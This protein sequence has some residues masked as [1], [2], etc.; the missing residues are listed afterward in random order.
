MLPFRPLTLE[1]KAAVQAVVYPTD[2]RNCDLCF[3]NLMSWRFL[4]DTE[5][6]FVDGFLLLYF[7]ADGH[8]AYLFPVGMGDGVEMTRRLM[9]DAEERGHAF[10]MLGVCEDNMQR[11]KAAFPQ[12]F[13]ET[14]RNYADYVYERTALASLAGK[15]LQSKRNFVN[16]FVAAHPDYTYA[17]LTAAD[18][19]EC[20]ELEAQWCEQK[21]TNSARLSYADERRSMAYV[22]AHWDELGAT[23]G[24][25]RVDGRMVAFTLG[26]PI[27][28]DTFDVCVEKAD[29]SVVGAYAVINRDFACHIPE[30]FRY[31]N[32][33]EDLGIDGLRQAKLSYR[34]ALLLHKFTLMAHH[35]LATD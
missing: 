12:L 24:V 33:E 28:H 32:R 31:V 6:A 13:V 3:M 7:K 29:T 26:A 23:G 17:P 5:V 10:L 27:N 14:D 19:P 11:L 15:H 9:A 25:I 8:P 22:M 21:P 4:Y 20:R 30:Q 35:P 16:R 18:F 2:C 34:P 1:D